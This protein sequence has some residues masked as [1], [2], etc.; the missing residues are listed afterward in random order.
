MH[1]HNL[2]IKRKTQVNQRARLR[3]VKASS[4]HGK[5]DRCYSIVMTLLSNLFHSRRREVNTS[6]IMLQKH[7]PEELWPQSRRQPI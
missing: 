4:G 1:S 2:D 5:V 7:N 6:S 3:R